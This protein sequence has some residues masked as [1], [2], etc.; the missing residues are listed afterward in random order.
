MITTEFST[1]CLYDKKEFSHLVSSA[2]DRIGYSYDEILSRR[3]LVE[4]GWRHQGQANEELSFVVCGSLAEGIEP[5]DINKVIDRGLDVIRVAKNIICA[6]DVAIFRNCSGITVFQIERGPEMTPGNAVLHFYNCDSAF[7][8]TLLLKSA[9]LFHNSFILSRHRFMELA[10]GDRTDVDFLKSV[11]YQ[12]Y[13]NVVSFQCF[14]PGILDKWKLRPRFDW[15][16][17]DVIKKVAGIE[18]IVAPHVVNGSP[19]REVEWRMSFAK[20]EKALSFS[21][22]SASIKVYILLRLLFRKTEYLSSYQLKTAVFWITEKSPKHVLNDGMLISQ[23]LRVI[24]FL[25][26]C[27]K[28]CF[29]PHYMN[30]SW[31]VLTKKQATYQRTQLMLYTKRLIDEQGS[32]VLRIAELTPKLALIYKQLKQPKKHAEDEDLTRRTD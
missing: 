11:R 20:G 26:Q 2:L 21:L 15:P 12:T 30:P 27:V 3:Q 6:D 5:L 22:N 4:I 10:N 16:T 24:I 1:D 8:R 18:A 13:D 32:M 28:N 17:E 23:T 19:N 9:K 25:K 31:N 29:M 7:L 14:C